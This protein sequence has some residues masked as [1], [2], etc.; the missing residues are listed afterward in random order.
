MTSS[1]SSATLS[2]PHVVAVDVDDKRLRVV[3][4]DQREI[5]VPISWFEFL[6]NATPEERSDHS[7]IGGGV[8]IWWATL[9]DGISV[10]QLF[11]L[12]AD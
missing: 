6:A 7:I 4:Q 12:P 5:T 1:A 8:G 11:G 9:E 2:R 3:V 10:A